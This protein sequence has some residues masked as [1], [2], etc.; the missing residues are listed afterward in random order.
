MKLLLNL[1]LVM[2]ILVCSSSCSNDKSRSS[3]NS[4]A[5]LAQSAKQ[6]E[7]AITPIQE[8]EVV[9]TIP[10]D[11]G[12]FTEGLFY[13]NGFLYES[14]GLKMY[15]TLRK[16]DPETGKNLKIIH[17]PP[18]YFGEGIAL[19]NGKIYQMT[20][21]DKTCLVYDFNTFKQIKTYQ[22]SGEGWGLTTDGTSLILS[23]GTNMIR[24]IE[25]ESFNLTRTLAVLDGNR[26]LQFINELEIIN[27]ELWANIWQSDKI[28]RIDLTTGKV[29]AYIDL[30]PLYSY[31][32]NIPN[33]DVLNGI[34]YNKDD[35]IIYVTGK[36]WPY[37]FV[38][39][40]KS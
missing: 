10:H 40:V 33:L 36:Y 31:I 1:V 7:L 24:F 15:S 26:P 25:P 3:S 30:S 13:Y 14:T 28:A 19:L 12:A 39:K 9:K 32:K 16:V 22:Y 23:D 20:W 34:A 8:I 4:Q 5:Q 38:I 2:L 35:N 6:T 11:T 37:I 21:Q 18:Q 27:G 29:K 17:T